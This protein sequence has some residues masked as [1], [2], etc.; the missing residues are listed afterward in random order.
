MVLANS[1]EEAAMDRYDHLSITEREDIMLLWRDGEGVSQIA[2]EI[3][4]D[5]STVSREIRRNGWANPRTDRPSYRASTAQR[6]ADERRARCRRPRLLDDPGTRALVARLVRDERWSPEQVAG[7]L[8]R[9][10]PARSVSDTTTCRAIARG[11]LDREMPGG[12][13]A[14]R[15]LR[16]RGRRRHASGE[17]RGAYGVHVTH[18]MSERPPVVARRSRIG[19]WEGDTVAGREG[20]ACLVTQ[21]DRRS[22]HLVGGKAA[23][24]TSTEVGGVTM[25]SLAGMVVRTVTVDRGSEFACAASL[26]EG[27]GAPVYFCDSH[28]PWQKGTNENTNG[29]LRD[30]FP[31]GRSLDDVTDEEVRE[32]YDSLNHRPRKRL[33]WRC[34]CEVYFH[35]SLHLL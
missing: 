33:A 8:A 23:H 34:P 17:P 9:E 5:K 26:Q 30:W 12:R 14:R 27:L 11:D 15:F 24:K 20:G 19:D 35:R 29:L 18:E 4:R 31:K 1:H 7:R 22:G 16:H 28:Q 2:R 10:D 6:R 32:A 21:V 25:G 3:G 13:A